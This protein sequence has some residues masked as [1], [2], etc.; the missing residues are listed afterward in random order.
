VSR[1]A[2]AIAF[3][4]AALACAGL[5]AVIAGGYR[6]D[7]DTQLG[8]LRSVVVARATIPAR[9]PLRPADARRLL[10]VRR[11]PQRFAPGGALSAPE[12]AV[13]RAPAGP[14]PPGAYLL[15]A[16]LEAPGGHR[17]RP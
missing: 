17:R 14:I 11:V 8:P 6:A 13:G 7:L 12:Q 5:A 10:E 2:R 1:R 4:C 16:Q 9:R 15:G 3:G